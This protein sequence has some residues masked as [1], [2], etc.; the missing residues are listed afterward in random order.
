MRFCFSET[1]GPPPRLAVALQ[2]VLTAAVHCS[3]ALTEVRLYQL[4]PRQACPTLLG[5]PEESCQGNVRMYT[6]VYLYVAA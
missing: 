1:Q 3:S 4:E 6:G 5:K 2:L